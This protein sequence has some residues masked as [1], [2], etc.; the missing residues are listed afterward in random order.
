MANE[1][2]VKCP[3]CGAEANAPTTGESNF[4]KEGFRKHGKT[5]PKGEE[6]KARRDRAAFIREQN[7]KGV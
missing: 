7:R 1:R 2:K 5:P 6:T 3:T 4:G